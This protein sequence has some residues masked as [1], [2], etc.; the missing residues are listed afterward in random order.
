MTGL[1]LI[2]LG[3]P[4]STS[5]KDVKK[6]LGEFLMDERVI[7][8]DYWKRWLLIKGIVLNTRPAKSAE[9]Y[10]KVWTEEGSPLMVHSV[11][12]AKKVQEKLGSEIYVTIAMR[13]G[14]PSIANA[15][16]ELKE[17]GITKLVVLPLYPQHAMSST[18]TVV[19]KVKEEVKKQNAQW[20]MNIIPAFYDEPRY[21]TN[22]CD[23]I[24]KE[25]NV[26]DYDKI[27]FSYHGIPERQVIKT[28][29]TKSH[30]KI[31]GSCCNTPSP[32]H[33]TCYRHQAFETTK[34]VV[35]HLNWSEDMA[36][37]TFQSRLGRAEWLKPYNALTLAELPKQGV[38]KI[39]V[40][41]PAFVAD[42]LETLEEM[43]ME[44]K[45]IFLGAGGERFDVVTCLND[46]DNWATTISEW[47][48]EA[49]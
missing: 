12:L 34:S 27:V 3:T 44:G 31:D 20:K 21:I 5:K 8:I 38:K 7:D 40:I 32:A 22:L 24:E 49:F 10:K 15:I 46:D 2:N 13:Y 47:T 39:A 28:D 41:M 29:T 26:G 9:A 4:E 17:K 1:L 16:K 42:C 48:K 18:E 6:Y 25:I 14:N 33:K 43:R 19:E 30:C 23:S 11:N 45:E 35:K 36:I 37:N